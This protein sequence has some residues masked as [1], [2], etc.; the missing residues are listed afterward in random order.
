M[1]E[2]DLTRTT[3]IADLPALE[4]VFL[5]GMPRLVG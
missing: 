5:S 4:K 3:R 1:V 2:D